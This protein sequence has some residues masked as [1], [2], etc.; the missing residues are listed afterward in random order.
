MVEMTRLSYPCGGSSHERIDGIND[1]IVETVTVVSD[2]VM[3]VGLFLFSCWVFFVDGKERV[4]E[5]GIGT[6][7][8]GGGSSPFIAWK[9]N[10]VR[11]AVLGSESSC[12]ERNREGLW[13][14]FIITIIIIII[15]MGVLF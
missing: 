10:G 5:K 7:V 15:C 13:D 6:C 1:I 12:M 14:L 2:R 11:L 4:K 3:F 9:G 8:V